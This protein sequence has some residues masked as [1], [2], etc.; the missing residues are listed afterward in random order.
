MSCSSI[1]SSGAYQYLDTPQLSYTQD[2]DGLHFSWTAVEGAKKYVLQKNIYGSWKTLLES[3]EC[4]YTDTENVYGQEVTYRVYAKTEVSGYIKADEC[5]V[6]ST[7]FGVPSGLAVKSEGFNQ[8]YITWEKAIGAEGYI[9]YRATSKD[10]EYQEVKKFSSPSVTSYYDGKLKLGQ[11]YY[12]KVLAYGG[13]EIHWCEEIASGTSKMI[14]PTMETVHYC[15]PTS[16]KIRWEKV[17]IADGYYVYRKSTSGSWKKIATI[18]KNSTLSYT[19]KKAKGMYEYA[20]CAYKEDG[21]K[22]HVSDKPEPI[23]AYTLSKPT[24]KSITQVENSPSVKIT[25]NKVKNANEYRVYRKIG[26]KGSWSLRKTTYGNDTSCTMKIEPGKT[27]YWK[28]IPVM[29]KDKVIYIIGEE[30]K[31]KSYSFSLPKLKYDFV[32]SCS[33]TKKRNEIK[34]K[35]KNNGSQ[36]L[37]I[38]SANAALLDGEESSGMNDRELK[39]VSSSGKKL[40]STTLKKSSTKTLYFD[41][42]GSST[43]FHKGSVLQLQFKYDGLYYIIY[44]SADGASPDL[45]YLE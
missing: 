17:D 42:V 26:S 10:G 23:K 30:S 12:Y 38:Y 34:I 21:G 6:T 22:K 28:V 43:R 13:K 7:L 25:W 35:I 5:I 20:V 41:I 9:L 32:T 44:I 40:S 39:L 15:S 2:A 3:A 27:Y 29:E 31:S 1:G 16:I 36:S 33:K 4:A 24:I 45:Y 14:K 37:Y 18:K 19:D 11:K 8:L